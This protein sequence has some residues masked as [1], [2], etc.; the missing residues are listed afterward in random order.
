MRLN[1]KV[2]I[3]I[4]VVGLLAVLGAIIFKSFIDKDIKNDEIESRQEIFKQI[5]NEKLKTKEAI[6][7]T[8]AVGFSSNSLLIN[9][10]KLNNRKK[11]F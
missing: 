1:T 11:L 5:L 8:N 7:L 2:S 3:I 10:L 9:A 6:G 4:T